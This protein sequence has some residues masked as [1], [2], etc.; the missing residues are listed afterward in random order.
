MR[1]NDDAW[2]LVIDPQVIFADP[3]SDWAAPRF[4]DAMAVIAA[5]APL[6]GDR[7]IVTRW[8]PAPP[9]RGSWQAYFKRWTF[10]DRPPDDPVFGLVPG[11]RHL[12]SFDTVDLPTFGKWGR[13]LESLLG[14]TPNLVLTGCATDCCVISTALAAADSGARVRVVADGCAGSS[15]ENHAAALHLMGLYDPQIKVVRSR[16]L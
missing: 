4:N 16:Q 5:I 13:R 14:P 8:V 6:F 11:A 15:D 10:A 2:L 9:Y 12:S 7:V 1:I 3:S